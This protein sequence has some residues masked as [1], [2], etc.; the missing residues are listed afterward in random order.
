MLSR[1][2][3][4]RDLARRRAWHAAR[5][6]SMAP[7]SAA[8]RAGDQ[9]RIERLDRPNG[10]RPGQTACARRDISR[11][12]SPRAR[13]DVQRRRVGKRD[14]RTHT[15]RR[16]RPAPSCRERCGDWELSG[17]IANDKIGEAD[18]AGPILHVARGGEHGS[19]AG[20]ADNQRTT[21]GRAQ[22]RKLPGAIVK[23]T[24]SGRHVGL[25]AARAR[26]RWS[27]H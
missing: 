17:R 21:R 11:P 4:C 22:I 26:K 1:G 10:R 6:P 15:G 18:M 3:S 25:A 12:I 14:H 23:E 2:R 9:P 20:G 8:W 7:P 27:I 5:G 16:R 24:A 19:M 13:P